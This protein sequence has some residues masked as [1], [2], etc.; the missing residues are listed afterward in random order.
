MSALH[1]KTL[2][3][4]LAADAVTDVLT[5]ISG[6]LPP[7]P[8]DAY[9]T[10]NPPSEFVSII[11]N[12]WP[13]SGECSSI[14]TI[15]NRHLT[16]PVPP[17]IE[18][19]LIWT[20]LPIFHPALVADSITT[21][22]EQDGLWGFTGNSSPPPSPSTLPLC[23]PAL[24]EWDV[25]IESLV[26]SEKGTVEEGATVRRAGDEVH[27]F[28][29]KR[30]VEEEWETAWFVNPPVGVYI[31]TYSHRV[32]SLNW[33]SIAGSFVSAFPPT[34]GAQRL[35]S[36][37]GIAHIHVFAKRKLSQDVPKNGI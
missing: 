16:I 6:E 25:T 30:W 31:N 10:A 2:L 4:G 18:H 19:T 9:F 12:D 24:A 8:S 26:R 36:V 1:D 21:R 23:L 28:V 3:K 20:R 5:P 22:V 29:K 34:P 37:P 15:N 7:V 13:Y 32:I 27:N 35:Q 14:Y 11:Q 33:I 17:E